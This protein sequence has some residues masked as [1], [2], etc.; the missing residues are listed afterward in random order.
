MPIDWDD[1]NG[2]DFYYRDLPAEPFWYEHE[3]TSPGSFSLDQ[4]GALVEYFE[5]KSWTTLWF[6][7][8]GLSPLP[9]AF[10]LL[11][12]TAIAT[13]VAPSAIAYQA[14]NE[15][16]VCS[17]L[18]GTAGQA[19]TSQRIGKLVAQV[20][21]FR[22]QFE[23][24]AV[25]VIFN[26]KAIQGLSESSRQAALRSHV[27][28]LRQGGMAFFDTMNVQGE[29][30]DSLETAIVEAGFY[31]PLYELNRWYRKALT[32]TGI[33]HMFVLGMPMI[34]Q[35]DDYPY[36]HKHGAPEFER[37]TKILRDIAAEYRSRTESEYEREQSSVTP[38]TKQ[39]QVIYSTG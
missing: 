8:C 23:N 9:R 37:D 12:F 30:R 18:S 27:T 33:P 21:D 36:P 16:L 13:D 31:L 3:T 34:P 11:G 6:P 4:L 25:D 22:T 24:D 7:G 20:H 1:H 39:A 32:D 35:R 29:R 38:Q 26:V 2:W 5:E 15:S 19:S 17:L 14:G 10:A 28:A